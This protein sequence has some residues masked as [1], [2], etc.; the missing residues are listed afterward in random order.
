M[1][2]LER[3]R[4]RRLPLGRVLAAMHRARAAG[5]WSA[6][7]ELLGQALAIT[8]AD[9]ALRVQHGHALKEAGRADDAVAAY[10]AAAAAMPA[11]T[12]V[13]LH[14]SALLAREGRVEEAVRGYADIV[15]LDPAHVEAGRALRHLGG[16]DTLPAG[17]LSRDA[18]ARRMVALGSALEETGL[19]VAQWV[20]A[21]AYPAAAYDLFHRHHPTPP[22]PSDELP[23]G[24]EVVVLAG[25]ATAAMLRV[26]LVSLQDQ[27]VAAAT[28]TV[29][30]TEALA[31]HPVASVAGEATPV[32][33]VE[34][35]AIRDSATT[36]LAIVAA[37]AMLAPPALAW[38]AYAAARTGAAVV[39]GDHDRAVPDWRHGA[40]H[41]AP[42]LFGQ[43]DP[44]LIAATDD[45]PL[46]AMTTP[47]FLAES[48]AGLDVDSGPDVV[49]RL[50]LTA[51]S[52]RVCHVPRRLASG[53]RLPE[54]ARTAP[55]A[56]DALV[57]GET[58]AVA[59]SVGKVGGPEAD[60]AI[61]CHTAGDGTAIHRT[62][63]AAPRIPRT[64]AIVIPT[65]DA[66]SL[67]RGCIASLRA[68][69]THPDRLRFLVVDNRSSDPALA[70]VLAGPAVRR[71]A[72]DEPFNWS[73]A[74]NLAA[75]VAGGDAGLLLFANNDLVMRSQRWDEHVDGHLARAGV[76]ALGARLLYPDQ[77]YQ[78]A[79]VAFGVGEHSLS[80]H[81][82]IGR[83]AD[84]GGPGGRWLRTRTVAAVTGAFLATTR[85]MFD[86]VG[87]FDERL[88]IGYNDIDWCLRVRAAGRRVLYVPAITAEH[89]ESATRSLNID[90]DR[91]AFDEAE[92][93]WLARRW[94][95]AL[96]FDP[97][98]NPQWALGGRP[99]DGYREPA[100]RE[101]LRWIDRAGE[102]WV[103]RT[104]SAGR[105]E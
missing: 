51:G 11:D 5:D 83:R 25:G 38:L 102:P 98:Y 15:A 37:G 6:T 101:V 44:D 48:L 80:M 72:M 95:E 20:G 14:L 7:A 75:A 21:S 8:P 58:V 41:L 43:F 97:G 71:L 28:I 81:E 57:P 31:Q 1:T 30:A 33:F 92:L 65:R 103:A 67:L 49:R 91:I 9:A 4:R 77:T 24:V 36:P 56:E 68:T 52:G 19:L 79:G 23:G 87:G 69:A 82:G 32:S 96:R 59:P 89:L 78:H 45:P 73:R 62:V 26:T 47:S 3:W 17:A 70:E 66:A 61:E 86:A 94:G 40:V 12:D 39:H 64:I 63:A 104:A 13:R 55:V 99:F 84:E 27:T 105:G 34:R 100:L 29:V 46:A 74:N 93:G 85:S 22:P 18:V 42:T 76:G 60:L 54:V 90:R 35:L 16:R 53:Y 2:W 50:L 10:R 88:A